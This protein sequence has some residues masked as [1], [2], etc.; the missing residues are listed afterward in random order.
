[1]SSAAGHPIPW[2]DAPLPRG[3]AHGLHNA[4]VQ[5][6]SGG[7]Q[8]PVIHGGHKKGNTFAEGPTR[9]PLQESMP[10]P[11]CYLPCTPSWGA[12]VKSYPPGLM[13]ATA[14]CCPHANTQKPLTNAHAGARRDQGL[15]ARVARRQ[16]RRAR[17][18]PAAPRPHPRTRLCTPCARVPAWCLGRRACASP[19]MAC[20]TPP[21]AQCLF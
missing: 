8:I 21:P 11:W 15:Y 18:P 13:Q 14:A 9:H 1:M 20:P 6:C 2:G 12:R 10:S 4:S 17:Q 16:P 3:P 19:H 5:Q 7:T